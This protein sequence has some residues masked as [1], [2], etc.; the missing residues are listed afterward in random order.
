[1]TFFFAIT[2]SGHCFYAAVSYSLS[3]PPLVRIYTSEYF[4]NFF[5]IIR[6]M[7]GG[8]P[9]GPP[10]ARSAPGCTFHSEFCKSSNC[11]TVVCAALRFLLCYVCISNPV[12]N[13]RLSH[14]LCFGTMYRWVSMCTSPC[15][16]NAHVYNVYNTL[17]TYTLNVI[18]LWL[19]QTNE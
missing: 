1:M 3:L 10:I 18:C 6:P 5:F 13:S 4:R 11:M 15:L 12:K 19:Q 9:P 7:G 14:K 8:R 17:Y 2:P 16:S